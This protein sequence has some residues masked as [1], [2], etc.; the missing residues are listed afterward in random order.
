MPS[1]YMQLTNR[2]L[3]RL[4]EVEITESD[5]ASVRGIQST[6]KDAILDTVREI[7]TSRIDW[8]F[9]AVEHSQDLEAGVEEYAW[10]LNFTAVDWNSFQLQK[11]D[12]LNINHK[13]LKPIQREEW[14]SNLRD[15]DYDSESSG[16]NIPDYVFPSHGQGWGVSPS[17]NEAYPIKFRYYKNPDDLDAYNDEVTIPSKFDYVIIGGAL[18]HLNQ[19]KEN[20][21]GAQMARSIYENGIK[22]MVNALLPNTTYL[23]GTQ[24]NFG[25]GQW[26]S[27]GFYWGEPR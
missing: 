15:Q 23:Y 6:A 19:F 7:N 8:P 20:A 27:T 24:V 17:P 1:T 25:G 14:Y 22:N 26:Q 10:P 16:L 13:L 9:N 21:E 2:L 11:D 12:T 5:F 18:S 4:N 3:R